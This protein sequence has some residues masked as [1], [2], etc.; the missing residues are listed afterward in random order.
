VIR[1]HAE[2][3]ERSKV[4]IFCAGVLAGAVAVMIGELLGALLSLLSY[5]SGRF[6]H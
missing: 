6:W 2:R 3:A 1:E 5:S 4:A